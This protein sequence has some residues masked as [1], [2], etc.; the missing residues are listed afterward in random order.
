MVIVITNHN[1][2]R[3]TTT[4]AT[5]WKKS[6][7]FYIYF[8][9]LVCINPKN[10]TKNVV[11]CRQREYV[12]PS[13]TVIKRQNVKTTVSPSQILPMYGWIKRRKSLI[14]ILLVTD[15]DF[16]FLLFFFISLM[17]HLQIV[18]VYVIFKHYEK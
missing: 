16:F 15:F 13:E 8:N 14:K 11:I 18:A 9:S 7:C 10:K 1:M 2:Y 5:D 17:V 3:T 6:E 4:A 12:L